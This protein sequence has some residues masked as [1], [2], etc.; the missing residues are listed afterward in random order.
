MPLQFLNM[1]KNRAS[2]MAYSS[3]L[4]DWS[5]RGSTP[6]RLIVRPP[7]AWPGCAQRGHALFDGVLT[8]YGETLPLSQCGWMPYGL[9]DA[10]VRYVHGFSWLCDLRSLSCEK[11]MGAD[12]RRCARAMITSWMSYYSHWDKDTW[13][14][15]IVGQ[16]L[17]MWLSH[18]E[19]FGQ[20]DGLDE[21]A[22][23]FEH[24]FF[25]AAIRQARHL[26]HVFSQK[27]TDIKSIGHFRA[28]KGLL[29]AGVGFEGYEG[30]IEQAL[31]EITRGIDE[32]IAGD[33]SHRSRSPQALQDVLKVLLDVRMAL[34]SADYPLPE[35]IQ[36]AIDRMGPALRFFRYNDKGFGLFNGS[37]EGNR[38]VLDSV[39]RQCGVRGKAMNSLP[40]TGFERIVHGRTTLLVD[41]GKAGENV[42]H[43]GP[44]SFEMVYGRQRVFVNCGHHPLDDEWADA[45]NAAPAHTSLTMDDR[46][47]VAG[48]PS[49][50]SREDH[51][52]AT[53]LEAAHE[54]YV[55]V[56]GFTHHR[57]LYVSDQGH[58]IRGEDTLTASHDPQKSIQAVIRFHLHPKVMVSLIR[59][60]QEAL[61]RLPGGVGWRFHYSA[62]RLA[63]EDSVYLG[64][65]GQVRKTKQ[66]AIY[67]QVSCKQAQILWA[68]QREG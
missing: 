15:G 47:P 5:L 44:L 21:D 64:E 17:A 20:F 51:K 68:V 11:G 34:Q 36:H 19:F 8:H 32:Q 6:D 28:A 41:T 57:R 35:N 59:D 62:G 65:G 49:Y 61:L 14:P 9:S 38:D 39:M 46:N 40:C 30:W 12:A 4:Y 1:I 56:N 7:D 58:D 45:L 43:T 52:N 33:G 54:G 10:W 26:S 2:Q 63:L 27:N 66:L 50:S 24:A 60:G 22:D 55:S 42:A 37:Q 53:L 67:G 3:T 23:R 16:R 13:T 18:Y 31:S 48:K 25:E 29:Y